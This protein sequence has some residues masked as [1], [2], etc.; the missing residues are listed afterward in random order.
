LQSL[1]FRKEQQLVT[2]GMATAFTVTVISLAIDVWLSPSGSV[3]LAERLHLAMV[4]DPFVVTW[5]AVGIGNVARMQFF[6]L[7]TSLGAE[8]K[9]AGRLRIPAKHA[10]AGRAGNSRSFGT[11]GAARWKRAGGS[12]PG[13]AVLRRQAAVLGRVRVWHGCARVWLWAYFLPQRG[14]AVVG[15]ILVPR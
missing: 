1:N 10:G 4:S 13:G 11:I 8:P 2:A 6:S 15:A 7:R 5:L 9:L 3:P 12:C 14:G